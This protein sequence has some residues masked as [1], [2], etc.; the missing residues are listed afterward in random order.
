[1]ISTSRQ[2]ALT[3][4]GTVAVALGLVLGAAAPAAAHNYVVS[5]TPADGEILTAVPE[6]FVITTNDI[7]LDLSGEAA[8]FGMLITDETGA[9]YGDGCVA[10]D[11]RSMST[12]AALGPEG[13]YTLT[14]QLISADGH[15]LSDSLSF[16]YEPRDG[17]SADSGST[18]APVCPGRS[19][20]IDGE[21]APGAD[22]SADPI[23]ESAVV[24]AIIG[25][26]VGVLALVAAI[27]AVLMARSRRGSGDDD[28][29][30][31]DTNETGAHEPD[32]NAANT[33]SDD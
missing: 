6:M 1:M 29:N 31:T 32:A 23:D 10:V 11:G 4:I 2:H 15:T 5:S 25:V 28:T 20:T 9:Y 16:R 3:A 17:A 18:S 14:F 12:A 27:V 8:G 21:N 7:L 33:P 22:A 19:G 26:S 13:D 24:L 30:D